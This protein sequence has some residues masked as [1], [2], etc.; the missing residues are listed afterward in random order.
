MGYWD[1]LREELEERVKALDESIQRLL[2]NGH[3]RCKSYSVVDAN[4]QKMTLVKCL[5]L[6]EELDPSRK[7]ARKDSAE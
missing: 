5:N 6:I 4:A 3:D 7:E 2:S 1:A